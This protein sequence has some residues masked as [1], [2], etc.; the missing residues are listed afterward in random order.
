MFHTATLKAEPV[1]TCA[2]KTQ[3]STNQQKIQLESM[4]S[5]LTLLVAANKLQAQQVEGATG[6]GVC[7]FILTSQPKALHQCMSRS[8]TYFELH[9]CMYRD[10]LCWGQQC[11]Q[12]G[13][14][15]ASASSFTV[16][17]GSCKS[18]PHVWRKRTE[19][20]CSILL[21]GN[22]AHSAQAYS[23]SPAA[24]PHDHIRQEA[25]SEK[26]H[27]VLSCLRQT[28]LAKLWWASQSGHPGIPKVV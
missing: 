5:A 25:P 7:A 24:P 17:P 15:S 19:P 4:W 22:G 10:C 16:P 23:S 28:K 27:N 11:I 14:G 20:H 8:H 26:M 1:S 21:S 9:M 2:L 3:W 13:Q 6:K 18:W 12:V